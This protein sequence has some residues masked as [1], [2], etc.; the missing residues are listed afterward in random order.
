MKAIPHRSSNYF[1]TVCCAGIG[2]DR[3]WRRLYPVPFQ[4]LDGDRKFT[5]WNWVKYRFTR[6]RTDRR[7]ESQ[8]VDPASIKLNG[9]MKASERARVLAPIIRRSPAHAS[10]EG[11][12]LTLVRPRAVQFGWQRKPLNQLREETVKHQAL[13]SQLSL[14]DNKARPFTPCP[15]EFHCSW[16]DSEGAK[17][18]HTCDDWETVA[19]FGRRSSDRGEAAALASLKQTYEVDYFGRGLVFALGTHSR[20][21]A[22]WL[23]VGL[24]RLDEDTQGQLAL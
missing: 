10:Q 8:K 2:R 4:L 7:V 13:A 21:S 19:A 6:P 12:S 9:D 24:L 16:T 18:R 1:E 5:R 14:L 20:R 23:L 3:R 17:H 15:F 11:E 22:Q